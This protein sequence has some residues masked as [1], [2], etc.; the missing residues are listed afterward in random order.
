MTYVV[1]ISR[2]NFHVKGEFLI[3]SVMIP[4][5]LQLCPTSSVYIKQTR[6]EKVCVPCVH[7]THR[8]KAKST[9]HKMSRK[10]IINAIYRTQ[11]K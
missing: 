3:H 7:K 11:H 4:A 8:M 6:R 10:C 2:V 1:V 5:S 9:T